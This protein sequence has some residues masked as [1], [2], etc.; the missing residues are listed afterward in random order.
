MNDVRPMTDAAK[1]EI[2]AGY[3]KDITREALEKVGMISQRMQ[4]E[5]DALRAELA[6]ARRERDALREELREATD[7]MDDPA[8]NTLVTLPEAI[9]A[10]V[11]AYRSSVEWKE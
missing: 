4:E 10:L 3:L 1:V 7:A 8:I 9:R 11:S 6:E 5:I 2:F